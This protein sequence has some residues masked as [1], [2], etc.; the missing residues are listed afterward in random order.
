MKM[1]TPYMFMMTLQAQLF[2]YHKKYKL[3]LPKITSTCLQT[4]ILF[5]NG[6][7]GNEPK[8]IAVYYGAFGYN[9]DDEHIYA[10]RI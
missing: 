1:K 2:S 3:Q 8:E 5:Q 6:R 7:S 10:Y 4:Y 9:C